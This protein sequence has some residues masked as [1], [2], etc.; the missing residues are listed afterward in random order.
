MWSSTMEFEIL[1][2]LLFMHLCEGLGVDF[3]CWLW[4][5]WLEFIEFGGSHRLDDVFI[6]VLMYELYEFLFGRF[7]Y[8][9]RSLLC[10]FF[11]SVLTRL[12]T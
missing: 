9:R 3:R 12:K 8:I 5:W 11:L 4:F 6:D 1:T 10:C 7:V 2:Y